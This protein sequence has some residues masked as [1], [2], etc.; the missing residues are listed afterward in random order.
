MAG[1]FLRHF[2][3]IKV[4]TGLTNLNQ[5]DLGWNDFIQLNLSTFDLLTNEIK[6]LD[7]RHNE[8]LKKVIKTCKLK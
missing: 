2:N 5:L 7:L 4:W 1:N 6:K 3:N 8:K